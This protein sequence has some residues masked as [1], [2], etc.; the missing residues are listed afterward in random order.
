MQT[1]RSQDTW[2]HCRPSEGNPHLSAR[3]LHCNCCLELLGRH[4]EGPSSDC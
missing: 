4:E 2:R 1:G 3:S